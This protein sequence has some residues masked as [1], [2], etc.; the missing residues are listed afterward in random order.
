MGAIQKL[1]ESHVQGIYVHSLQIGKNVEQVNFYYNEK[2]LFPSISFN[3][4]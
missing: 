3:C 1:I 4:I 2:L